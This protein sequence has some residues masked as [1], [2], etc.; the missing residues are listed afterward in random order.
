MEVPGLH[1]RRTTD[2]LRGGLDLRTV[3]VGMLREGDH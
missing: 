3:L 2:R 1:V